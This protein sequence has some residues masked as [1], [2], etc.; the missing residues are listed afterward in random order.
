V[1]HWSRNNCRVGDQLTEVPPENLAGFESHFSYIFAGFTLISRIRQNAGF[2][3]LANVSNRTSG[4][5]RFA[6]AVS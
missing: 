5:G 2:G 4:H 6:D 1:I 3:G